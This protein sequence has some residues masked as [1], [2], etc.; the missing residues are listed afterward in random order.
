MASHFGCAVIPARVKHPR[1]KA[2]VEASVGIA[3][4]WVVARL[5]NRDFFSLE[6]LRLAIR[7]LLE[8]LN[9]RPFKKLPG[10]RRSAYEE[11]DKPALRP[12]PASPYEY[13]EIHKATVG[14]DYHIEFDG[15]WYSVPYQLVRKKVEVRVTS[16]T[17]E[18]LHR[19]KRIAS[20]G[21]S[22]N[23]GNH[24]TNDE[25]RPKAHLEYS[26]RSLTQLLSSAEN[27]GP[28]TKQIIELAFESTTGEQ[29]Y[30]R[31]F[32]IL[33]LGKEFGQERLE[34]ACNRGLA[35]GAVSFRSIRSILQHGLDRQPLPND[36]PARI[37]VL[38]PNI[39]G[40]QYF[41]SKGEKSC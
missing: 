16:S 25:H 20:H 35:T 28:A 31:S 40:A 41:T 2:K 37:T 33:K 29:A 1:D 26:K 36:L 12:L 27:C 39:R 9:T 34:A 11:L 10:C 3:T 38:H 5:R 19:G 17:V 18:I 32:G 24:S 30:N 7:Q 8:D 14:F 23:K 22:F 21:R 13:S 15:H 4:R 6:E